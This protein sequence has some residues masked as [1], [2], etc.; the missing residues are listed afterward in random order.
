LIQQ[1]AEKG[2]NYGCVIIPEGLLSH[3]SSFKH[4]IKELN[5]LFSKCDSIEDIVEIQEKL[6]KDNKYIRSVLTPWSFTLYETLPGFMKIQL[7]TE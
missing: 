5:Q 2:K 1:R 7:V 6:Y 3:I 4:L